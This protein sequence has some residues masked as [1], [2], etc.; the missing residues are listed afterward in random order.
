MKVILNE[1]LEASQWP[2]ATSKKNF[3]LSMAS[4]L[5]KTSS[6]RLVAAPDLQGADLESSFIRMVS[7]A[8]SGHHA[9]RVAPHDLWYVVLC[10]I[11]STINAAP[12]P[13][14]DLFTSS[15]EKQTILVPTTNIATLPLDFIVD[16]LREIVPSD[17]D[18][19]LPNFSTHTTASRMV[20]HAAFA[21]A[22]KSYYS[23]MT[24]MCGLP[25]IEFTGTSEDWDSF[26]RN[27]REISALLESTLSGFTL[28]KTN[29]EWG[30]DNTATP[31]STEYFDGIVEQVDRIQGLINGGDQGFVQDF[32]SQQ[33]VGSG[34]EKDV[35][36]WIAR[37]YTNK[38]KALKNF[39]PCLSI[40][41]FKNADTGLDFSMVCGAFGSRVEDDIRVAEYGA[42]TFVH[43][44]PA[45]QS[46][47]QVVRVSSMDE[48]KTD[49]WEIEP[50]L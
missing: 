22:V 19:F 23:Y 10:E 35:T 48:A 39:N 36:G 44:E 42:L 31:I 6:Y 28:P 13:F 25:A 2:R 8:Y 27:I 26:G 16:G 24:F 34:G 45:P 21:D 3:A 49:E 9:V 46:H 5:P 41:P 15:G 47:F 11:A 14:R 17:V 1:T 20:C 7:K 30:R 32:Y 12:E 38:T 50:I 40:V 29:N 4:N 37:F 33:N 18:L 43:G